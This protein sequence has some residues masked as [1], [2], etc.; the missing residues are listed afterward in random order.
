MGIF[1]RELCTQIFIH[2]PLKPFLPRTNR[3]LGTK[4][5]LVKIKT[6]LALNR[7]SARRIG[8]KDK[9]GLRLPR[10]RMCLVSQAPGTIRTRFGIMASGFKREFA[11]SRLEEA[12]TRLV[13]QEV[14][15]TVPCRTRP[16]G[17][18]AYSPGSARGRNP[19]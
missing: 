1:S 9:A 13:W 8:D 17:T 14:Q 3:I 4:T 19:A 6:L 15:N 12:T 16:A 5:M 2:R 18:R 11:S 7:F 10:F